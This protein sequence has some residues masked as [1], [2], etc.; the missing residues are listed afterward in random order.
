MV[1]YFEGIP[2]QEQ[3]ASRDQMKADSL[4]ELFVFFFSFFGDNYTETGF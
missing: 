3:T 2:Q 4:A 1:V